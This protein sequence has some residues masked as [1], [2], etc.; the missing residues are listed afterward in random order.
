MKIKRSLLFTLLIV[1][2]LILSFGA[3]FG[4]S[5]AL[6]PGVPQEVPEEFNTLWEVWQLLLQDYVNKEALDPEELTQGAIEGL[7]EALGDPYTYY[8]DVETY[9]LAL[10]GLE[11]SFEG[12]GAFVTMEDGELTVV[13]PIA[14]T[15]AEEAGIR[16][17]DRILEIDGET[18]SG[19]TLT[20]A[21]L[22][23]R[24]PQGTMVT[25]LVLHQ[26]ETDPV[27]IEIIRERIDVDSVY[28]EMLPDNIAHIQ[29]TYFSLHTSG[30]LSAIL[31]DAL[32]DG[33]VGIVLDL[34][35]NPGGYLHIVVDVA[36]EFLSGGVVLYEEDSEGN[37]QAWNAKPGGLATDLPLAVLVDGGSASASEVLAGALQDRERAPLIGTTTYG[38]G[39]VQV[40]RELSDGSA[41]YV[42]TARWLTP[43]GRQI[44]GEGLDP[45][46]VVEITEEDIESGRDP[47]L[48]FAIE[49][50]KAQL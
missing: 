49:Y 19:M 28:L 24:G 38:K 23:I 37:L 42:T 39:S 1:L 46:F 26:G 16:A 8:L 25:L 21:V 7:L 4:F 35:G 22:I 43:N 11:G 29:I 48:E 3:G 33:A 47:Q 44:E 6:S 18:T 50:I 32:S 9:E 14:G 17:G 20:E 34:R 30:E 45:D 10:S 31:N 2:L 5:R 41:L 27:V 40:I 13:S 36:S 15:P 12:I